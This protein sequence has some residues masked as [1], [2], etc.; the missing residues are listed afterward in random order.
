MPQANIF[1][2]CWT[3]FNAGRSGLGLFSLALQFT[4]VFW[5]V[6]YRWARSFRASQNVENMLGV[7]SQTYQAPVLIAQTGKRFR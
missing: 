3:F 6:A 1:M 7:L 2:P 5:P 4:I